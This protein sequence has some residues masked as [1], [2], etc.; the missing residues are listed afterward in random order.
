MD[1]APRQAHGSIRCVIAAKTLDKPS[2][3]PRKIVEIDAQL[4]DDVASRC[5]SFLSTTAFINQELHLAARGL[6]SPYKI[7]E[8]PAAVTS[9][10]SNKTNKERARDS[11]KTRKQYDEQFNEFWGT[12]QSSPSKANGQSKPKALDAWVEAIKQET[13][14]RLIEAAQKAVKEVQR[15]QQADEFCAP[16]PDAFRW[17][18]DGRYTVLLEDHAPAQVQKKHEPK[19]PAYRDFTAERLAQ[20]GSNQQDVLK[21]MGMEF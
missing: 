10:R 1:I 11:Y 14:E 18:R 17:L 19:H 13:P 20:E 15:L 5:P 16:L 7:S 12:Y 4:F 6:D 2:K 8:P 21:S 9:E 3:N